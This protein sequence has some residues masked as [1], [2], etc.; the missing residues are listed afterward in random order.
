MTKRCKMLG[1]LKE[2]RE[3][4][5]SRAAEQRRLDHIA[6]VVTSITDIVGAVYHSA[7]NG[8][9]FANN[10][11][12]EERT[13]ATVEF[14]SSVA[15]LAKEIEFAIKNAKND[16]QVA[17]T[18]SKLENS[19]TQY[20]TDCIDEFKRA[21]W[22]RSNAKR[23]ADTKN[24]RR[25]ARSIL[26]VSFDVE[27]EDRAFTEGQVNDFMT[28]K[29]QIIVVKN[30]D[31]AHA[32]D[33]PNSEVVEE[34][35]SE[36]MYSWY[37]TDAMNR[38]PDRSPSGARIEDI[39]KSFKAT[40]NAIKVKE[41]EKR[42]KPSE[43][44]KAEPEA[45][46]VA[47]ASE[48]KP[49]KNLY[50]PFVNS[51]GNDEHAEM[52]L[53]LHAILTGEIWEGTY[54]GVSAPCC[55][56]CKMM[57]EIINN[58]LP[59][60]NIIRIDYGDFH[61]N[62]QRT[63]PPSFLDLAV[64]EKDGKKVVT[65]GGIEVPGANIAS[66]EM[67]VKYRDEIRE[68]YLDTTVHMR[69]QSEKNRYN[70][71]VEAKNENPTSK[72]IAAVAKA[73]N[74]LVEAAKAR[75]ER[76]FKVHTVKTQQVKAVITE[77]KKQIGK[78][79]LAQARKELA[80]Y[81]EAKINAA[82]AEAA[83]NEAVAEKEAAQA[84]YDKA[85]NK[86]ERT[87][88]KKVG[89]KAKLEKREG[90][91]KAAGEVLRKAEEKEKAAIEA[92]TLAEDAKKAG[93]KARK[94]L[95]SL[96]A[97]QANEEVARKEVE[98]AQKALRKAMR[99]KEAEKVEAPEDS[100]GAGGEGSNQKVGK[101]RGRSRARQKDPREDSAKRQQKDQKHQHLKRFEK[102][103]FLQGYNFGDRLS[104]SAGQYNVGK[105]KL[106]SKIR[107]TEDDKVLLAHRKAAE[108]GSIRLLAEGNHS[109]D[110]ADKI[111]GLIESLKR[112]EIQPGTVICLERK[113]V[114]DNLG[115]VDVIMLADI[116]RNNNT[117]GA[118]L[119]KL[120]PWLKEDMPIY[121]DAQLYNAVRDYN[122]TPQG[123][124]NPVMVVG[125]EG[126]KIKYSEE[127]IREEQK[128]AIRELEKL[129]QDRSKSSYNNPQGL[130]EQ[131]EEQ[132]KKV[133]RINDL[134]R[135]L[136]GIIGKDVDK[137]SV[138]Y[139]AARE[140]VMVAKLE[141]I[142]STG[143]QVIFPVGAAHDENLEMQLR[144]K[145]IAVEVE[146]PMRVESKEK[147]NIEVYAQPTSSN[148]TSHADFKL[149]HSEE[150]HK[151]PSVFAEAFKKSETGTFVDRLKQRKGSDEPDI[152][153][154]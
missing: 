147:V 77:M 78:E 116:I 126:K 96:T 141:Q 76:A 34:F 100:K 109:T 25:I 90:A 6:E 57:I 120:P 149:V 5:I 36:H 46:R 58:V 113:Q 48:R 117:P 115:M 86:A 139:D 142:A 80:Q 124:K 83:K 38:G 59:P 72:A 45:R 91:E 130:E 33:D 95:K 28:K 122:S 56:R 152:P 94:L 52:K 19:I 43:E 144:F 13:T 134:A 85:H 63:R 136:P 32:A 69:Y 20:I 14:C 3:E 35:N 107:A 73:A 54:I 143:R 131:I 112:G 148:V 97:V 1:D 123:E 153:R 132:R 133:E 140:K 105:L 24:L 88:A 53:V 2:R 150:K 137:D 151:A 87:R 102:F 93:K 29:Y 104:E 103:E 119:I 84:A 16:K 79:A 22:K 42:G 39:H 12:S 108:S 75:V 106:T 7:V 128:K 18:I 51:R 125:V 92:S 135:E 60:E 21:D 82:E 8:W 49:V 66:V 121:K 10:K 127:L 70:R 4:R 64:E 118:R 26:Q 17:D 145:G 65:I 47:E 61:G 68:E 114:G 138:L 99:K 71:K 23:E 110:H 11:D 55:P 37:P 62:A 101:K 146:R 50:S 98:A 31:V 154:R 27:K 81:D 89:D 9:V 40:L 15:K 129:E 111:I 74:G 30:R 41:L 67:F 44:E